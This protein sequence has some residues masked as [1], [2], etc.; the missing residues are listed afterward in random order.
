MLKN[1]KTAQKGYEMFLRRDL[2]ETARRFAKFPVVAILGPRQSGKTTLVKNVFSQHAYLNFE[3]LDTRTFAKNDPNRFLLE[4]EN[5]HGIIID[6]FQ[7]VP[8]F[9]SYIQIEADEKKRPGYFILTGSHP[10]YVYPGP[11]ARQTTAD[12]G[13]GP[14]N[15][16][17]SFT[18]SL[19]GR[20]GILTLLPFSINEL[21][22]NNKLNTIDDTMYKGGYPQLHSQNFTPQELL[23]SYIHS[24]IERDVRDLINVVDLSIF[25]KFMQLCA[26]RIGQSLNISDIATN[27]GIEQ[28]V[29]TRWISVLESSYI[30]F[31]LKPY[32]KNFNKRVTKTPKLFFYDTGI[33]CSL[34]NI[35]SPEDLALSSFRGHMFENM[36]IADFYKQYY[37]L[38]LEAPLYFWREQNGRTEVDCII[39]MGINL[40]ALE[41]KSGQTINSDFF[42]GLN[43]WTELSGSD[44][45]HNYLIYAGQHEQTRTVAHVVGWKQAGTLVKKIENQ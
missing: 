35:R 37:N 14:R 28:K 16:M 34:L 21:M 10:A 7:H 45:S 9:L 23:P 18:Q 30:L 31:L 32:H 12:F 4:F 36:I 13:Q 15:L 3:N 42:D 19:A 27:C 38:G 43:K 8:E 40:K 39:D 29:I 17:D 25:K 6:E 33:A 5:P 1:D 20:V 11:Q 24:Y 26:G 44:R 2:E 22:E 41:I